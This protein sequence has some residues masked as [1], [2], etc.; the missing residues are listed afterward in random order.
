MSE[1]PSVTRT[2]GKQNEADQNAPQGKHDDIG[3]KLHEMQEQMAAMQRQMKEQE[4]AHQNQIAALNSRNGNEDL[5]IPTAEEH[6]EQVMAE[7]PQGNPA[8]SREAVAA[9]N[10]RFRLGQLRRRKELHDL[11]ELEQKAQ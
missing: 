7:E 2:R 1:R 8:P 4:V 5:R 11:V 6:Y 9:A 10:D 3:A